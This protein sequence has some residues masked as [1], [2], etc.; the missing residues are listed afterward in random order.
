MILVDE[1]QLLKAAEE[2]ARRAHKGQKDKSGEDY[3]GHVSRV[4]GRCESMEAKIVGMLH[5][6]VED[7]DVTVEEI[8]GNFGD[9]VAD[10]VFAMTHQDGEEWWDYIAR[11]EKNPISRQVK[12]S[13]LIDNSNL[14]RLKKVTLTDVRRQEKYNKTLQRLMDP[15]R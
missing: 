8:R 10:A 12:I 7:T 14:S 5:D 15:E 2:L 11:V 6:T 1:M 9:R 13:D 4:S 3:F